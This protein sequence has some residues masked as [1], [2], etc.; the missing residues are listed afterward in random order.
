MG[1]IPVITINSEEEENIYLREKKGY[2]HVKILENIEIAYE[3]DIESLEG[4]TV[5][6][7]DENGNLITSTTTD[8]NGMYEFV[9]PVIAT[10]LMVAVKGGTNVITGE[11]FEGNGN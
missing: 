4:S 6:V 5:E 7:Y 8:V 10:I 3:K 11:E 1:D 2:I 9:S